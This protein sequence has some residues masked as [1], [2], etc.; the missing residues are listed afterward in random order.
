MAT[1]ISM[2]R[3]AAQIRIF[4]LILDIILSSNRLVAADLSIVPEWNVTANQSDSNSC[5]LAIDNNLQDVV[6]FTGDIV[7]T[8]SVQLTANGTAALIRIPKGALVYAER[9]ENMLNCQMKYVSF[10]TDKPCFFVS[11]HPNLRLFLQGNSG[12]GSSISISQLPANTSASFCSD[13]GVGSKGQHSS[14][15]GQKNHCQAYE[16]DDMVSCNLSPYNTCSFKFPGNCNVTLGNRVVEFHCLDDDVHS[17]RKALIVYPPGI[18]TLNL[19]R[20]SI[21]ELNVNTF[22]TLKSLKSLF[23]A[24]NELVVLPKGLLSGLPNLQYLYLSGNQINSLDEAFFAETNKLIVLDISD[25]SL[26]GLH[27]GLFMGLTNL[28][29]LWL[30]GNQINSLDEAF[31]AETN[32]LI[33]LHIT[34]NNL[35]VLPKGLFM[36]LTNLEYLWLGGNQINSLDEALFDKTNKLISLDFIDNNLTVLPKGLFMG[37]TNLQYLYLR[38]NQINSLDEALFNETNTL[39]KLDISNNNLTSLPKGLFIGL[40]NLEYLWLGGNQIN[41]LDEA[42]FDETNTLIELD[43]SNN[44]LT[45]L[46]KGLFMGLTNLEYLWLGGNQINSLD[47]A[48]FNETHKLIVLHI[49]NNNLTSLPK[50]LFMGLTNLEYLNVIGNQI[51]SLHQ[52][53]FNETKRLII[54]NFHHN[55]LVQLSNNLFRGLRNLETLALSENKIINVN[56][57]VFRDLINLQYLYLLNNNFKALRFDVFQYTRKIVFLDISGNK[58]IN[59]P[60]ISKLRQLFYL[61]VKGNK[62]TGITNETFS[63]LPNQTELIASQHEICE[64]YVSEDIRCIA[65]EDRSPFLTC[66][67]LLSDRILMVVMWLIGLNAIGGNIF[68]LSRRQKIVDKNKVQTFLLRNLAMSDLLMGFYMLLIASADIYFGQYFPMQAE[69]WRSG[70]TCRIAG[71]ISIVSSQ[72]SVFFVTLISIDRFVSIKYHKSRRKLGQKSSAVVAGMLWIM[73]LLLGIVPSSLAGKN[74][75]FYDNSHVCIGLPLSKRQLYN[76]EVS[77]EWTKICVDVDIC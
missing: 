24:Y 30:G 34:N 20:R 18:I 27:K 28:E 16:F 14:R 52:N 25:N 41:S 64:C 37:L 61:N 46:P 3:L 38:V 66:D 72:A 71:A 51:N 7:Q 33:V 35:T 40:T 65:V 26:T 21:V 6:K 55:N 50:G 48:L 58:L 1:D 59:I 31:F 9:Q 19:T 49:T 45:N 13:G 42:L 67:R 17:S 60:D 36:G 74:D 5:D 15:V 22:M 57:E 54:L 63:D 12:N 75:L 53:L 11:R 32:K 10:T 39:I 29:Y 2:W 4:T 73:A 43:I 62:L 77:E 70:I 68:V 56:K 69:A 8:C 44:N 23:L 76:T 47:E